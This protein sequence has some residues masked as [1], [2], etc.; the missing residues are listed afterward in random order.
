MK[1]AC[2]VLQKRIWTEDEGANAVLGALRRGGYSLEEV[3]FLLQADEKKL[4][5]TLTQLKGETENLFLLCARAALPVV[6][7]YIADIFSEKD[8]VYAFENAAIFQSGACCLCLLSAD[9]TKTG[10]DFAIKACI[11]YLQKKQGGRLDNLVMRTVG[12]SDVRVLSL[13]AEAE[14]YAEGKVR[15]E[16]TRKYDEDV[17][18]IIYDPSSPKMVVDEVTRRL[19]EGLG[20]TVYAMND[21]SLEEQLL[22]LLK[23]RKKKLSVAESFTGGGI[24]KRITSVSGAS[25]VYFEGIN[26][27]DERSKQKRLGVSE[28]GLRTAGAVSEQ[29]AYEMALGL[30]NTGDCDFAIATTGLA[31]PKSDRSFLPVGLC[32]IA[33][34]TKEKVFV[35]RYK[36]D[37]NRKEIVEKAINYALFLACQQLKNL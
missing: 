13:L 5:A 30:L 25:E 18:E 15:I 31:G 24:A 23:L 34:G 1:N 32:F 36:F 37:G 10:A 20:D 35:Y 19:L 14:R 9:E 6:R 7:T 21:V 11:P 8:V 28:L 26:A 33:A 3:R 12:A 17:L 16:R 4:R 22:S 27:Y 2:I 29:T